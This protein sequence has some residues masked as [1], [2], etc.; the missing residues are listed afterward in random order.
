MNFHASNMPVSR[1]QN[2]TGISRC[3]V[4]RFVF[5]CEIHHSRYFRVIS[6]YLAQ[7]RVMVL[8]R[9]IGATINFIEASVLF[10]RVT[11]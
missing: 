8:P 9:V 11:Q 3:C 2:G 6:I 7:S 1:F 10:T 4:F 5:L